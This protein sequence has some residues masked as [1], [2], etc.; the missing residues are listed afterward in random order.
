MIQLTYISSAAHP[1]DTAALVGLLQ[2]CLANNR[3]D[4]VTGMLVYGNETFLQ[5]LEGEAAVVDPLYEKIARDPRHGNVKS[6]VRR[7]IDTRQYSDWNM[8]F[9]RIADEDLSEV[10]GLIDFSEKKFTFKY[11]A[12]HADDA[13]RLM[14]HFSSWD[15]LLRQIEEKDEAVRHLKGM[16]AHARGCVEMATLVLESVA[17]AGAVGRLEG[18]HLR[19]CEVGFGALRQVPGMVGAGEGSLG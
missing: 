11:L 2:T 16:L 14:D 1:M 18:E 15:P 13:R 19:L 5:T 8:G 4:G 10:H 12:G 6:F 17:A 3:R 7:E 9:K